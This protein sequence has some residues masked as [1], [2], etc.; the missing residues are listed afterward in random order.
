MVQFDAFLVVPLSKWFYADFFVFLPISCTLTLTGLPPPGYPV[1]PIHVP[2]HLCYGC[3]CMLCAPDFRLSYLPYQLVAMAILYTWLVCHNATSFFA[4]PCSFCID[5][6]Y[7]LISSYVSVFR[8][9]LLFANKR[10][11][12][13]RHPLRVT[14]AS[15]N[16]SLICLLDRL[17]FFWDYFQCLAT[18]EP[19]FMLHKYMNQIICM[20][21]KQTLA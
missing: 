10:L 4:A 12:R 6:G 20:V 5:R 3:C 2:G 13:Y 16:E 15:R 1:P 14:L 9:R 7:F 21:L 11:Y 19:S 17:F 8:F 18:E